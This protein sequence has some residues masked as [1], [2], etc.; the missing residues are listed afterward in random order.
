MV[1]AHKALTML[2]LA[3]TV[4]I[5]PAVSHAMLRASFE[6]TLEESAGSYTVRRSEYV[7]KNRPT[8]LELGSHVVELIAV[9]DESGS[10]SLQ[11]SV[12]R[13]PTLPSELVLPISRSFP[14][15]LGGPLEFSASFGETTASGAIMLHRFNGNEQPRP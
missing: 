5:L 6:L 15:T 9:V 1:G 8:Q 11:V 14:G 2:L 3:M 4:G 13:K 7:E 10:Y 12:S